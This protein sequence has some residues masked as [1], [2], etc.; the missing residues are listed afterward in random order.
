MPYYLG[1]LQWRIGTAPRSRL[2]AGSPTSTAEAIYNSWRNIPEN[3]ALAQ[4]VTGYSL[5]RSKSN[6]VEYIPQELVAKQIDEGSFEVY[7]KSERRQYHRLKLAEFSVH[8]TDAI[9]H[10]NPW[11]QRPIYNRAPNDPRPV[12][13]NIV[14]AE[15][16]EIARLN[17]PTCKANRKLKDKRLHSPCKAHQSAYDFKCATKQEGMR[18]KRSERAQRKREV[19][20]ARVVA[21]HNRQEQRHEQR[22]LNR[23]SK[24]RLSAPPDNPL[25]PGDAEYVSAYKRLCRLIG[26]E[27]GKRYRGY[28]LSVEGRVVLKP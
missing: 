27:R 22:L 1:K 14:K 13:A 8:W 23:A 2:V 6:R 3:A 19:K 26:L 16:R 7:L 10:K 4:Y 17:C 24:M 11:Y 9:T 18:R 12:Q 5:K 21:K 15:Q 20:E 25:R 28:P